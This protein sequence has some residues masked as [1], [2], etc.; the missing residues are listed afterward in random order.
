MLSCFKVWREKS[1]VELHIVRRPIAGNEAPY[2]LS[3]DLDGFTFYYRDDYDDDGLA[4]LL[5]GVRPELIICVGWADKGYLKLVRNR[6]A[7]VVAA[8]AID[9]QWHGTLRQMLGVVWSRF[10]L[11]RFFDHVWVPG[12]R[13]EYFAG[14]LG[15]SE[16]KIVDGYYVA[17]STNFTPI[18][19]TIVDAPAKRLVFVGR[20]VEFKGLLELWQAFI[21]Y[22]D[23]HESDLELWCI[24][25]GPLE[26]DSPNHPKLR[27]FG[28]IQPKDFATTLSGGGIFVLPSK[29]E[30]WGLVVHE[31]A[32]A[33]FPLVLSSK[34]GAGDQFLGP[35][36]G[37]LLDDVSSESI[38]RAIEE[39]DSLSHEQLA[40]MSC[41]SEAR[42]VSLDHL[43]WCSQANSFLGRRNLESTN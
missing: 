23:K 19:K 36:N 18:C 9:N 31:F 33:G 34:V 32:L 12:K 17:N 35:E 4:T 6:K 43:Y 29:F 26:K 11:T 24:G 2:E 38:Y 20:Y 37:I 39:I 22:H 41:E 25:T 15:F 10:F 21:N 13:Q 30:P 28:F 5:A 40:A 42:G 7:G 16:K 3:Y 27:H 14:L 8:I 1:G